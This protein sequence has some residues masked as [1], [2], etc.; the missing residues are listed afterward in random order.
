MKSFW[1]ELQTTTELSFEQL[2]WSRK[3][4]FVEILALLPPVIALFWRIGVSSGIARAL[5][6]AGG[7]FSAMMTTAYLQ[8]LVLMVS[9]FYGTALIADEVENKTLTYITTRPV[10]KWILLVGKYLAYVLIGTGITF[11]SIFMT[12]II[13]YSMEGWDRLFDQS[14]VLC[15]DLAVVLLGIVA[16]GA[17]FC[18]LGTATK[19][20]LV[21]GL[22]FCAGWESLITYLPGVTRKLTVMHFLQSLFPH[23]S[24][25]EIALLFPN[26]SAGIGESLGMILFYTTLFFGLSLYVFHRKQY[27]FDQ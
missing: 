18:F 26:Q 20:P 7:L 16:Y 11:H 25:Q 19:R 2:F 15:K 21:I 13:L 24:G 23:I 8:F 12:Y 6:S 1:R 9:L 3:T 4:L 5:V 27:L 22:T 10:P 14:A 17:I